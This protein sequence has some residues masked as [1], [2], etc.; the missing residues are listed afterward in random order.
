MSEP[1]DEWPRHKF[2]MALE[3]SRENLDDFHKSVM[4]GSHT[5]GEEHDLTFSEPVADDDEEVTESK[6][7]AFLDEKVC[8]LSFQFL[9]HSYH[10]LEIA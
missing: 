4:G 2:D 10:L 6:I 3:P 1:L 5:I 8:I 9:L 7:R